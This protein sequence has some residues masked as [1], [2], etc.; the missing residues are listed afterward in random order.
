MSSFVCLRSDSLE[1]DLEAEFIV[2]KGRFNDLLRE[3]SQEKLGG[4]GKEA[5]QR[6]ALSKRPVPA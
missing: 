6:R 1:V 2:N 4:W 5:K 3:R